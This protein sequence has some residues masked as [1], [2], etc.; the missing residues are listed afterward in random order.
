MN[1]DIRDILRRA[2]RSIGLSADAADQLAEGID[3]TKVDL[4]TNDDEPFQWRKVNGYD[5]LHYVGPPEDYQRYSLEQLRDHGGGAA[6][7]LSMR[8]ADTPPE[9]YDADG[10]EMSVDEAIEAQPLPHRPADG[11][12]CR[13]TYLPIVRPTSP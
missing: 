2:A 1:L 7:L 5:E 9:C 4:E 3:L 12:E 13:C 6:R 8:D 10:T 11:R